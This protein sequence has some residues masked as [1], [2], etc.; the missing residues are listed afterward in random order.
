M[1]EFSGTPDR[2]QVRAINEQMS[3]KLLGAPAQPLA[4]GTYALRVLE[5]R[6]RVSGAVR[7][8]PLG[9]L[10]RDGRHYLVSPDPGRDWVRNLTGDPGC[11]LL[12]GEERTS[13]RASRAGGDEAAGA[14][15][16]YLSAV[17]TP[18][19]VRAFPFA[20]DAGPA[21]IREHLDQLAVFRLSPTEGS[22]A[23]GTPA[24]D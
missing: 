17:T 18:W 13:W 10:L 16:A 2:A 20:P 1:A 8:T 14:V 7:R 3:G 24:D 5:T 11:A 15:K 6:G 12:A 19:A 4:E 22:P 21:E 23:D 9:V